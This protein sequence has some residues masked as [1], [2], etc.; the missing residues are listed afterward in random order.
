MYPFKR[1]VHLREVPIYRGSSVHCVWHLSFDRNQMTGLHYRYIA[2][3]VINQT[4]LQQL[5]LL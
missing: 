2:R 4:C 3:E 5:E 1:D